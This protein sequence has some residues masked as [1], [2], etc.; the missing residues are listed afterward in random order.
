MR[1]GTNAE[2][3]R[4]V[5]VRPLAVGVCAAL[6]GLILL[7]FSP[8][9]AA[10]RRGG[11]AAAPHYSRP[12][13]RPN[14]PRNRGSQGYQRRG[15]P[16]Q[17]RGSLRREP[18]TGYGR[19]M[20]G[21]GRPGQA[22]P[23]RGENFSQ[24][25]GYRPA[26]PGAYRGGGN[27]RQALPSG[28]RY[29]NPGT[30]PPGHLG[31]WLNQHHSQQEQEQLLRNDPSFRQLPQRDQQRLMHQ[32]QQVDRM[33]PQ[34]RE[35][36]VA[37]A[38]MIEHMSPEERAQLSESSRQ[39]HEL[40]PDRQALV[41]RAFRDLRS[42]PPDQRQTVLNSERYQGMFSPQERNMLGNLLRAEPYEPR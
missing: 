3:M 18:M 12:A 21:Y 35:R 29:M 38:E 36:Q 37:R 5:A 20:E 2:R 42:V 15:F 9:V 16:A 10:Q 27:V 32:L 4:A 26:Y 19:P 30:P 17:N 24:P 34:E 1:I 13:G 40:P 33:S 14:A 7:L 23:Q 41:G 6:A 11:H 22:F 25:G 39:F 28:E 8:Q 31:F